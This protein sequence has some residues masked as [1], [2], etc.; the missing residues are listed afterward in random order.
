[1]LIQTWIQ[2]LLSTM[3]QISFDGILSNLMEYNL[4]KSQFNANNCFLC[5][6]LHVENTSNFNLY[7]NE[8][9]NSLIGR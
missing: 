8:N 5:S 6:L 2:L 7:S 9:L 4:M 3:V 1:M